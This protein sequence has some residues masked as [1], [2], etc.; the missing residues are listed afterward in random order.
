MMSHLNNKLPVF[1]FNN[2]LFTGEFPRVDILI[3]TETIYVHCSYII[4]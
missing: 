3:P 2:T 1:V 4:L